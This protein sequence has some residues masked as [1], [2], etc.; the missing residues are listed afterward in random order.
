[1][2]SPSRPP[3]EPI[4]PEARPAL[5]EPLECLLTDLVDGEP[6]TREERRAL[7]EALGGPEELARAE[8]TARAAA[9]L[10]RRL[11][12]P[13]PPA[14][15]APAVLRHA[16]RRRPHLAPPAPRLQ[17]ELWVAAAAVVTLLVCWVTLVAQR[18]AY[19]ARLAGDLR[20]VESSPAP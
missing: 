11:A 9:S 10:A 18:R 13:T 5:S 6:L 2:T 8:E 14:T 19:E 20:P 3:H 12:A 7:E 4:T 1:M 16:R 17:L 15:L